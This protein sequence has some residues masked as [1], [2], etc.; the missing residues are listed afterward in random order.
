MCCKDGGL[1]FP[2]GYILTCSRSL[3]HTLAV[4]LAKETPMYANC[5][6]N[7]DRIFATQATTA[8]SCTRLNATTFLIIEDD[9]FGE[10]PHIYV[11]IY[12]NLI[13][14]SDTG[15]NS[16]RNI[17]KTITSVRDYIETY[18]TPS[19]DNSPLNPKG[20]KPYFILC[21]HA[22]YDHILGISH[23]L[24]TN[25]SIIASSHDPSFILNDLPTHSLCKFLKIHTPTYT[26]THWARHQE[27]ITHPSDSSP[28]RLQTLHIPGHTPDSL[29]WYDIDE[30]HLYIG[31]TF[32]ERRRKISIPDL[33]DTEAAIVFPQEGNWIDYMAS[34]DL[35]VSFVQ[36]QNAI[37]RRKWD[38]SGDEEC[39]RVKIGCGHVT[40]M[41]DAEEMATEV[42][43]LFWKIIEGRL[44]PTR[45]E[46]KW[47]VV[48]DYWFEGGRARYSVLA[49]R[50]LA[51]DAR[52][53]FWGFVEDLS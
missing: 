30:H 18:P 26:I 44:L 19:N 1:H 33:P 45:S 15:C 35:I 22:H 24:P 4:T 20:Q 53:H 38:E 39:P 51:E 48:F 42:Q 10:Q 25:H 50:H 8:F 21:S 2:Q 16:P 9:S 11:K 41:G 13:V 5:R 49:P 29:A 43:A 52:R 36:H 27:Y 12:T 6:S 3:Y 23:F 17:H 7:V 34:L 47:G 32:Y 37:L 31:D 40:A 14:I 46:E 28:L